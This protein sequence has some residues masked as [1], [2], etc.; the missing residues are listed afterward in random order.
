MEEKTYV[1]CKC[2]KWIQKHSYNH[3]LATKKHK[4]YVWEQNCHDAD[5]TIPPYIEEITNNA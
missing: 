5:V 2:G 4:R 3:H 1:K